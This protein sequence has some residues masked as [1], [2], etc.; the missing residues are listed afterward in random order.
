M[1][2]SND[3]GDSNSG[4]LSYMKQHYNH[5][6]SKDD[7]IPLF[8]LVPNAII[9]DL[10]GKAGRNV[11]Q[12][13]TST[14]TKVH[15]GTAK[16]G[17]NAS[18][19]VVKVTGS[20]DGCA[21]VAFQVLGKILRKFGFAC[22]YS[23]SLK[24]SFPRRFYQ[25]LVENKK[26]VE[27]VET[28]FGVLVEEEELS[29]ENFSFI[30]IFGAHDDIVKTVLSFMNEIYGLYYAGFVTECVQNSV[31]SS[32]SQDERLHSWQCKVDFYVP[33]KRAV[34]QII[35]D[36]FDGLFADGNEIKLS[37][38]KESEILIGGKLIKMVVFHL[39]GKLIDLLRAQHCI[40]QNMRDESDAEYDP[41]SFVRLDFKISKKSYEMSR[42][43]GRFNAENI[44]ECQGM[45]YEQE[46]GNCVG[47]C[48]EGKLFNVQLTF[49]SLMTV[50]LLD[51]MQL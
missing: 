40:F 18:L 20:A 11:R 50:E 39:G 1:K 31:H 15:I 37:S 7:L 17:L 34:K 6:H 23:P 26:L 35:K 12:L 13:A 24:V 2:P 42:R 49:K 4:A 21:E 51:S 30:E 3:L 45:K 28:K 14:R 43:G 29:V 46:K 22:R 33:C 19:N 16:N 5:L 41:G 27:S 48:L 36:D 9:G 25:H 10:T 32:I 47:V 38:I 44:R 8:M